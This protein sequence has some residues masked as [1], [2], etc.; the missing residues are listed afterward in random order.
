M[1]KDTDIEYADSTS[2]LQMGCDGC[3]L[4]NLLQNNR[5]CYAGNLTIKYGGRA[6][7]PVSFDKPQIFP[8]R[9]DVAL[10]W[11]DLTGKTRTFKPWLANLPR[12]IFLDDMGD[13]FT[14]SL[15]LDW[16]APYLQRMADSP[17][18]WLLLTKR[19]NRMAQFATVHE[20]PK[21]VWPGVSITSEKK[22]GRLEQLA[23]ITSGGPKWVSYEPALGPI[24]WAEVVPRI[25][26]N[27]AWLVS[28]GISQKDRP[29]PLPWLRA[30]VLP[31]LASFVK[32]LGSVVQEPYYGNDARREQL[33]EMVS[34]RK[35]KIMIPAS[36]GFVEWKKGNG[37]PGPNAVFEYKAGDKGGSIDKWPDDL[38]AFRQ[39]PIQG[40]AKIEPAKVEPVLN[41]GQRDLF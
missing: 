37:Q 27:L 33:E 4:W 35:A 30:A 5:I 18:Q 25:C 12:I 9:L 32:Q 8:E 11:P 14:E 1:G 40:T 20:L 2:N 29:T 31:Y 38:K 3:E 26:P 21:N 15:P 41:R 19:G 23:G 36:R 24:N 28:G 7:W 13:T 6:G 34:A 22:L 39:M 10:S 16:L 17:H